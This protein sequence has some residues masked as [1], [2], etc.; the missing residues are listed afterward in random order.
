MCN[1]DSP[2]TLVI[3]FLKLLFP[4]QTV[5]ILLR[6]VVA[7]FMFLF[8]SL[9]YL[10]YLSNPSINFGI[11]TKRGYIFLFVRVSAVQRSSLL[12]VLRGSSITAVTTPTNFG[13]EL[14]PL[15]SSS[16]L[17]SSSASTFTSLLQ[18]DDFSLTFVATGLSWTRVS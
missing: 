7:F 5:G 12:S 16:L 17:P 15:L 6:L 4:F 9:Q 8:K 18:S 13:Q 3:S 11:I 14:L 1:Y 2:M 10:E